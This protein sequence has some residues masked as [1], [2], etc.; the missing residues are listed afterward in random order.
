MTP[1]TP[2]RTGR[3]ELGPMLDASTPELAEPQIA[4]L[5]QHLKLDGGDF[6]VT[7]DVEALRGLLLP[8]NGRAR[9]V[10]V[11]LLRGFSQRMAAA[12][13]GIDP[14]TLRRWGVRHREF[15]DA[16]KQAEGLGFSRVFERELYSRAM[17]GPEDRGSMRAL[18]LVTKARAAEYR[19]KSQVQM[20]V[21]HR[22]Q[23]ATTGAFGGWEQGDTLTT[24]P[25]VND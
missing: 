24:P 8:F 12:S 16:V 6:A 1:D 5:R 15:A 7:L 4:E 22:A 20:E 14:E 2:A 21:V 13:A 9:V 25:V 19:E 10:L 3:P 11:A 17:A 18:E 23:E